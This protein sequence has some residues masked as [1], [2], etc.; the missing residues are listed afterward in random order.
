M[1]VSG[2]GVCCLSRGE[3]LEV[4][5]ERRRRQRRWECRSRCEK[6]HFLRCHLWIKTNILPRQ[7]R[8]KCRESTQKRVAAFFSAGPYGYGYD[9][10]KA[11]HGG[12][13]GG[14]GGG[15]GAATERNVFGARGTFLGMHHIN[16]CMKD[17]V[18][19]DR[20]GTN[21]GKVQLKRDFLPQGGGPSSSSSLTSTV[22]REAPHPQQLC[23]I[24]L[25]KPAKLS[26]SLTHTH[27]HTRARALR[28]HCTVLYG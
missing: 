13:G 25:G 28:L 14:G 8:D 22:S 16:I 5:I 4:E 27:T 15:G 19:Q 9:A 24:C 21:V 12:D 7:A 11:W 2:L 10:E 6:R 26:L 17:N 1:S 18:C 23:S 20:L 3:V